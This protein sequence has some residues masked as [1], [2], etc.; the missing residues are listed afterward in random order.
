MLGISAKLY[1][2]I[3]SL[4]ATPDIRVIFVIFI[5]L[6]ISLNLHDPSLSGDGCNIRS[7]SLGCRSG[8]KVVSYK[9]D[10]QIDWFKKKTKKK[11]NRKK[12]NEEKE[13]KYK[14]TGLT[15]QIWNSHHKSLITK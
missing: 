4:A 12:T 7:N 8:C 14:L 5:I 2:R 1:P 13:K 11:T 6:I 9:C 3:L 10:N 15:R